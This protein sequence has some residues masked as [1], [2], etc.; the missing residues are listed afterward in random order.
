ML[1]VTAVAGC[2]P[3]APNWEQCGV[4]ALGQHTSALLEAHRDNESLRVS[5]CQLGGE[6]RPALTYAKAG[7]PAYTIE[8]DALRLELMGGSVRRVHASEI[9]LDGTARRFAPKILMGRLSRA[10]IRQFRSRTGQ[11]PP[12]WIGDTEA[13]WS[14][15]RPCEEA[16]RVDPQHQMRASAS[17]RLLS[18]SDPYRR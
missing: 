2:S 12:M 4:T 13:H 6:C 3:G 11:R 10:Q 18:D 15:E 5:I 8:P 9:L 16:R 14:A 7:L 1:L 17:E